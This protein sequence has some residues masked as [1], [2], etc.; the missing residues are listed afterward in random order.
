MGFAVKPAAACC[1]AP[2]QTLFTMNFI[3]S[4]LLF[5]LLVPAMGA[6][7]QALAQC[8]G[9]ALEI[10]DIAHKWIVTDAAGPEAEAFVDFIFKIN[11][12]E[13]G[14]YQDPAIDEDNFPRTYLTFSLKE[15]KLYVRE[16]EDDWYAFCVRR[17]D[18]ELR[19]YLIASNLF[20]AEEEFTLLLSLNE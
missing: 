4:F 13:T 16:G 20:N 1:S 15:N 10:E 8:E 9:P 14:Y 2:L 5:A 11:P 3:R 17:N 19:L 6:A 12:S 7:T 18:E